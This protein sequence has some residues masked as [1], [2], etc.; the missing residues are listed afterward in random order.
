MDQSEM[1]EAKG[2]SCNVVEEFCTNTSIHGLACVARQTR[3]L[4]RGLWVLVVLGGF[5]GLTLHL[6][7]ISWAYLEHQ[8]TE[9]TYEQRNGY[10]FPDVT[11]CNLQGIGV[12]NFK[13]TINGSPEFKNVLFEMEESLNTLD[14]N[15]SGHMDQSERW[16]S[17]NSAEALFWGLGNKAKDVDSAMLPQHT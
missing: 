15:T 2:S 14:G 5:T 10:K 13:K 7:H 12:S 8:S 17:F 6:I 16:F 9:S 4:T 3:N 11:V 1:K